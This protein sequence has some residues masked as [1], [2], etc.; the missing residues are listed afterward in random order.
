[1]E[2]AEIHHELARVYESQGKYREAETLYK[3]SLEIIERVL[4]EDYPDTAAC[5]N[6]LA[7]VYENQ[8]KYREAED[9]Y[10]KSIQIKE[11]VRGEN[12]SGSHNQS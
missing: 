5:Y 2:I 4:G 9:L 1:M 12:D 11:R 8:G 3:S 10:K 6:N 7:G